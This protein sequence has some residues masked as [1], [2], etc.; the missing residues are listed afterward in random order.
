ME[1]KKSEILFKEGKKF[2][3]G[4]VNSPVRA[5]KS[6]GG[7]PIF[8]ER[9]E[10]SKL[11]DVDGNEYI[12][13][14]GSWGPHIFG[15]NPPF[16]KEAVAAAL[17]NG[18]SFGAPTEMEVKMARLISSLVPSVEMVRMVNSGTEATM[19]AVRVAR[20]FTGRDKIIKFEGC[21]HGHADFF[22][23]K[24]GSGALTLGEPNS[25]GV[26]KGTASDTLIARYN[27]LENVRELVARN[28]N[29]IAALIIEP[30][31]GNMGVV[32]PTEDFI[33]GLRQLCTEEGIVFIFDEVMTGFRLAK[34]G[35]QE[36][37]GIKPDMTT[38]GKI[39]GGGLPVGAF[40]GK[41]EI[42][43]KLAPLGPVY[44]AGTLSGNPLAMAAGYAALSHIKEN[45]G[46][47]Q[48]LEDKADALEAGFRENH[49]K[50]GKSYR[51]NRIGSMI[52]LFFTE[53]PVYDFDTAVKSDTT[54][55]GKFFHGMLERGIYLPPAQFESWFLSTALTNT[56][57]E[58]TIKAH[59]EV[60]YSH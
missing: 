39:I 21:Y 14:I 31:V 34:G 36:V 16:I 58:K 7:N 20:G 56:D 44:Q 37:F 10:G 43:E 9:G 33:N 41:R 53:Q 45:P 35:A 40:G 25:P 32:I 17:Q 4:G 24:A 29:Q 51:I 50:L 55:F 59:F 27:D 30:V 18:S 26:T 42:M 8:M 1:I 5:F 47:Y 3:P 22:L 13:Y 12:D 6:V 52:S 28:R 49:A 19:S 38:F 48:E 11:F 15:H 57:I 60:L 2:I 23:I 46:I 54:L